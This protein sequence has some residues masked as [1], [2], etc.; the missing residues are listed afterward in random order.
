MEL[1]AKVVFFGR[2]PPHIHEWNSIRSV[3][4][5]L[6]TR[7]ISSMGHIIDFVGFSAE[8]IGSQVKFRLWVHAFM[9]VGSSLPALRLG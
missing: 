2:L 3:D 4:A 1:V 5:R 9:V 7:S 8:S 6:R